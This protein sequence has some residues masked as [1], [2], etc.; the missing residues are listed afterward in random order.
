[1]IF[2]SQ[3]GKGAC[4]LALFVC[5]FVFFRFQPKTN[6]Q[7]LKVCLMLELCKGDN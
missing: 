6:T 2:W 7:V 3:K 1:M 5:L 4:M